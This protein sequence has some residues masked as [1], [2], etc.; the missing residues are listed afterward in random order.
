MQ[1]QNPELY[2][3]VNVETDGP[4]PGPYSMLAFGMS[5]AGHPDLTF[6]AELKPVSNQFDEVALSVSGLDRNKLKVNGLD[7]KEAMEN[8]TNFIAEIKKIGRPVFLAAPAVWDG[9]FL[10]WYF[11]HFTGKSPFG[12]TGA[13]ID[14]RSFWMGAHNSEWSETQ[15]GRIMFQLNIKDLPHTHNAG[16]DAKELAAVFDKVLTYRNKIRLEAAG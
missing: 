1:N 16:E 7:P 5:V 13:G 9:M 15:K 14:L 10:H 2:V 6:Y 3:A 12:N 4:I 8:A 11:I